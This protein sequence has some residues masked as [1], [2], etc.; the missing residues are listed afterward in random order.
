VKLKFHR[1]AAADIQDSITWYDSKRAGLGS[2]FVGELN[3]IVQKISERPAESQREASYDGIEDI[4]MAILRRFP[5]R[6][7]FS[8]EP[9]GVFVLAVAH[10]RLE[11]T[12]WQDRI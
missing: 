2:E 10:H 7:V 12:Y 6:V 3:R 1:A 9:D 5:Y 4:R 11:Q 8:I